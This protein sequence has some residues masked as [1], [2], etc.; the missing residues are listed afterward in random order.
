MICSCVPFVRKVPVR[1]RRERSGTMSCAKGSSEKED[2]VCRLRLNEV[3][4]SLQTFLC[5]N[6]DVFDNYMFYKLKI[7]F[8]QDRGA[9]HR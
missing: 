1:K 2:V 8:P 6:L 9:V 5:I 7:F 3:S 4:W